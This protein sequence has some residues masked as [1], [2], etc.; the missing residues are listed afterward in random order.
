[1]SNLM[2]NNNI[3]I[4]IEAVIGIK[5][6]SSIRIKMESTVSQRELSTSMLNM[7]CSIDDAKEGWQC[8]LRGKK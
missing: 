6:L 3:K 7:L 2:S 8:S 1:M 5:F 4:E